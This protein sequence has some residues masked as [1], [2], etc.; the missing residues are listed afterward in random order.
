MVHISDYSKSNPERPEETVPPV[1][2]QLLYFVLGFLGLNVIALVVATVVRAVLSAQYP[3]PI[4]YAN[5][6]SHISYA[7]T[8]NIVSYVI[9][10]VL[11]FIAAFDVINR[12]RRQF[13]RPSVIV[14]GIGYGMLIIL[15]TIALN[16]IY[17]VFGIELS[18]NAN[19]S[20]VTAIMKAYPFF[21]LVAFVIA[22]P[23][24]EELTYRLG[25]FGLLKRVNRYLAYAGT[26]LVF[27]LIHFDFETTNL[28]NEL[29]NLP[30]YLVAGLLF[31]YIY[32]KEGLVASIYAHV[33]NNLV[34]FIASFIASDVIVR[35]I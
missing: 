35:I 16:S 2:K 34:S 1:L 24:V 27:G 25:L 6:L 29:L 5:A 23:M 33:T 28:L 11:M 3:D 9:L 10:L 13:Y 26:F 7:A 30:F 19:E 14:K 21:S 12:L 4:A 15:A 18:D 31:C 17:L 8:I 22:G 32:E 20:S